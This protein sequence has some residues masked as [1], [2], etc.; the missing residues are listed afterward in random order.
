MSMQHLKLISQF[1]WNISP[2]PNTCCAWMMLYYQVVII[3]SR[4]H[5][6]KQE[7]FTIAEYSTYCIALG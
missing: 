1:L 4:K 3:V 2:C 7:S 5:I 6:A